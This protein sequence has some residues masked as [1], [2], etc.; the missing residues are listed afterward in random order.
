MAIRLIRDNVVDFADYLKRV[1]RHADKLRRPDEYADAVLEAF[2]E[3][4]QE[5]GL[6][7]PWRKADGFR[8]RPHEL[9]IWAGI[10]GH[11]KSLLTGQVMLA[12]CAQGETVCIASLEMTPVR[13]IQR[14]VRQMLAGMHPTEDRVQNCIE[15][16]G[17]RMWLLDYQGTLDADTI[18][19]LGHYVARE[20]GVRQ[21]VVDSLMKLGIGVDDYTGQ[22][23]VIDQ[24]CAL[25]R[26]TGL[27]V[28]LVAHARK[29]QRETDRLDKWSVKGA[30]EITDQADN[31]LLVQR[32]PEDRPDASDPDL[33]LTVAKQRHGE[34]EGR[35][36]LWF[37]Q[38][39]LQHV[40]EPDMR[41]V[42]YG[43]L[44]AHIGA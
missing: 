3:G 40:E 38:Q 18:V 17:E 15:A 14:L 10:N 32:M 1:P 39:S 27:H 36:A 20:L 16:L 21:L 33:L 19:G 23:R 41:P 37:D 6:K 22:K 8:I 43:A 7:L 4:T 24:L 29:G 26:D 5:E 31:V 25:A 9:S 12:V 35:Y 13:T 42:P 28:H 30:T 2:R 34:F 11:R 44:A